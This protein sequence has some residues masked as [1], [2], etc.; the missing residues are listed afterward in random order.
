MNYKYPSPNPQLYKALIASY[1][2]CLENKPHVK[3]T[4]FHLTFEKSIHGLA[5][6]IQNRTYRPGLSNIFVVTHPK[7]REV[8]AANLRDR[9]VHHYIYDY[10]APHWERRFVPNSYACRPGKGP[11]RAGQDLR[12][13]IREHQRHRHAPLFYLQLDVQNFFP[14]IDLNVLDRLLSKHLENPHYLW[15]CKTVLF[16]RAT[17]KGNFKL[18][19]PKELWERLPRYKSLFA[20]PPDK[21]LPIGNLTSQFFANIYMNHLDQMIAHRLKGRF[22]YWQRYVDDILFF[23]E[24]VEDLKSIVPAVDT[25]LAR[26]LKMKLNVKKTMLQPLSRGLD[27]LGYWHKPDHQLVRQ[28]VVNNCKVRIKTYLEQQGERPTDP[29]T[30]CSALNSYMGYFR[31]ATSQRLRKRVLERIVSA[32]IFAG[33]IASDESSTKLLP[34]KDDTE[35]A[36]RAEKEEMLRV[37]FSATFVSG[38]EHGKALRRVPQYLKRWSPMSDILEAAGEHFR[39]SPASHANEPPDFRARRNRRA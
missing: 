24:N 30:M 8:I 11:L 29:A 26:E 10:M 19:S 13:F 36:E 7:P 17:E 35:K 34:V 23:G 5:L 4:S 6:E 16:H 21:G 1:F 2:R 20:A 27:H 14:S 39:D 15:L 38:D 3:K 25:F 9:I 32:E 18:T 22:L 37:E 28:R 31:Q 33:K 12:R